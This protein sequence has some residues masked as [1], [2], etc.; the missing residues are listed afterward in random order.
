MRFTK[1][2]KGRYNIASKTRRTWNGVVYDSEW[3]KLYAQQLSLRQKGGEIAK[4]ERQVPY[5]L[6]VNG[7]K[8]C[9]YILDFQV[10]YPDGRIE[11]IDCK[12]TPRM[13]SPEYK[14]KKKLMFAIYG[15]SLI[16]VYQKP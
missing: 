14:L 8:I 12:S 10:Y 15:I 6:S 7:H 2:R 1:K 5:I 11:Y 3:E 4:Y 13:V 16:E 9:K